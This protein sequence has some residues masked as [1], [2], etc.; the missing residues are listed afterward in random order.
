MSL[1][2]VHTEWDP[3]EE[4]IVG[5]MAGARIPVPDTGLHA[6]EFADLP[7]PQDIVSGPYPAHVVEQTEAELQELCD[8]LLAA[9]V[10]VRR[11]E[12]R[13]HS[14]PFGTPDWQTDGFYDYCPRDG[15]L[16]VGNTIIETPMVL[17][18]RFLEPFAYK[19]LF[20]EY[21]AEGARWISAPKPR[22]LDEIYDAT[23]PAGHRLR[24][25]EPAFDAANVLRF[26][27]DILYL[28]SD[29]GNELGWQWL[30]SV[31]G[32]Q[33]TVHPCRNL[34]AATHVDSTLVPL[35]PGLLLTNPA[36]VTDANLP[37]FLRG[38]DRIECPELVDTGFV[39]DRPY[40]ST[41]IGMNLLLLGP[42]QAVVDRR[43]VNLIRA[44]EHHG[45]DVLPLQLT[46]SR[47]LGGGFHCVTLDVRR[48]GLL[49][50]YR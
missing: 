20:L 25:L 30:Q 23:A 49:E 12:P 27:T 32:D 19:E 39:G 38:W 7:S 17:R 8:Q 21:F 47:T 6:V 45:I 48:T 29:S 33:Y 31:L 22:L 42:G 44:L 35:R 26:G 34:Y 46:H 37:E 9:G 5:T 43:Q 11:P 40:C 1:V 14:R 2:N 50:S 13:D 3:L 24:D 18:S 41:W 16:T 4:I 28:V 10:K 36:R 15:I